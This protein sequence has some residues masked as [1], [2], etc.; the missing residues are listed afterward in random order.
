M[1]ETTKLPY[2][3]V[4]GPLGE[5]FRVE[6]GEHLFTIGRLSSN[7]LALSDPQQLISRQNHCLI[8]KHPKGWQ[9]RD[10][11]SVNGTFVRRRETLEAVRGKR[12]LV[13]GE[14]LCLLGL[15]NEKP[16]Y[17]E[18]T[19]FDPAQ[20][21]RSPHLPVEPELCY[22]WSQAKLYRRYGEH[23]EE[24]VLRAKEHK[25]VRY[26]AHRNRTNGDSPV[27]CSSEELIEAVWGER[28]GVTE[29]NHLVS[30]LRRKIEVNS[31]EPK[32][33]ESVRGIGYRLAVREEE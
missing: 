15:L 20:T 23:H 11:G 7:D 5:D 33:L 3:Q 28:M 24:I 9:V 29:V 25:L 1:N 17:W 31:H 12:P 14:T 19:F 6:I 30:S 8:E 27:L 13:S 18:L 32:F 4:K 16:C 26:M 22:N 10:N 2:L 21:N